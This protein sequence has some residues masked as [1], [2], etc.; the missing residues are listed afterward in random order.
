MAD[1]AARLEPYLLLAR[2]TK[3][4]AAAKVVMDATAA[5]SGR[6]S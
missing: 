2:S 1:L 6:G 4:Q 3:G 5:V